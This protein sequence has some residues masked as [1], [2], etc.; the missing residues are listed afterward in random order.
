MT[1]E[2]DFLIDGDGETALILAHGAGASMHSDFMRTFATG[3]SAK[4]ICAVRFE[5]PYMQERQRKGNQR[6]PD[7][8]PRL[9][10]AYF[11]VIS[12]LRPRF[13]RLLIGG[14]S[15]G[16]RVASMLADRSRVEGVVCLGYPFHP[17]KSPEKLRVDHLRDLQCSTLIVQGTRDPL[18]SREEVATYPLSDAIR[19][20]WL[21]DGDHSFK[22][23][24][25]S[26]FTLDEHMRAAI[27]TVARFALEA[28]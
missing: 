28:L 25:R 5:F 16:G 6:P 19:L 14:K 2:S 11:Q 26:G 15:M 20:H 12:Q 22:P 27:D 4:G 1:E 24:V 23:R 10:D 3:L 9:L 18:G 8:M 7:R 13:E 17:P 21:E